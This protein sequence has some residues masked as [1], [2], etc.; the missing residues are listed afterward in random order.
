[1]QGLIY[2]LQQ[3]INN[4]ESESEQKINCLIKSNQIKQHRM[5]HRCV[6]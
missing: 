1:M 3:H 2:A 5:A 4:T 6:T